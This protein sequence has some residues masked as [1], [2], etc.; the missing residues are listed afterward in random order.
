MELIAVDDRVHS[1]AGWARAAAEVARPRDAPAGV[2]VASAAERLLGG[3]E[4]LLF[5]HVFTDLVRLLAGG[6]VRLLGRAGGHEGREG[7]H[8]EEEALA[9]AHGVAVLHRSG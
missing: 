1:V 3:P 4:G 5:A 6:F 8:H 9:A 2:E 7:G